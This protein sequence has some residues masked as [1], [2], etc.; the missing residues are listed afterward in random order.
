[1]AVVEALERVHEHDRSF[2]R[3]LLA[4][5]LGGGDEFLDVGLTTNPNRS[6]EAESV[7][8]SLK[9]VEAFL[10]RVVHHQVTFGGHGRGD[11]EGEGGLS[12]TRLAGEQGH[13]GRGQALTTKGI[14]DPF[15]TGADALVEVS[16]DLDGGDVGAEL[17]GVLEL[18]AH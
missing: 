1:M 12:G 8:G 4:E 10:C 2:A 9:L 18:D 17:G 5:T 11:G 14:V 6:I 3:V 15:D 13:H 16:R 7:V